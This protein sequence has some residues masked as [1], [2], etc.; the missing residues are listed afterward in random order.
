MLE[1]SPPVFRYDAADDPGNDP[2]GHR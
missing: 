2:G 1:T